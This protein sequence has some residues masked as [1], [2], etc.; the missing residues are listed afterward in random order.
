MLPA[1]LSF[2]ITD[3]PTRHGEPV[4]VNRYALN[5]FKGLKTNVQILQGELSDDLVPA[6]GRLHEADLS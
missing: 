2:F 6:E 1:L 3:L 5:S 4:N